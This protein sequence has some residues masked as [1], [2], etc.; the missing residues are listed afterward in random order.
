LEQLT[1]QLTIDNAT[2]EDWTHRKTEKDGLKLHFNVSAPLPK[3]LSQQ[4]KCGGI[5]DMDTG[6]IDLLHKIKETELLIPTPGVEGA[7]SSF[8]PDVVYKFKASRDEQQ[9][10]I[11]FSVHISTRAEEMH[12]ILSASPDSLKI[13]LR[14]RQGQLFEGGTR[15]DVTPISDLVKRVT[16][17]LSADEQNRADDILAGVN[18]GSAPLASAAAMGEPTHQ[19]RAGARKPRADRG[20]VN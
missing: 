10:S 3:L 2:I 18:E 19:G 9:F 17:D 15:V 7:S 12:A 11:A 20:T 6:R 1:E 5:Y 13:E 8:F 14:P 16:G 4:L